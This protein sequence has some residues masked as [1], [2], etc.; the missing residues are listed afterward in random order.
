MSTRRKWTDE[1]ASRALWFGRTGEA[2]LDGP[3]HA[4]ESRACFILQEPRFRGRY[5]AAPK[6]TQRR[7][8]EGGRDSSLQ[9]VSSPP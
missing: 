1:G 2:A 4:P 9:R 6:R 7:S 3:A 8:A 5:R